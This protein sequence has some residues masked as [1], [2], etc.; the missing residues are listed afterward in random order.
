MINNKVNLDVIDLIV[1]FLRYT[2]VVRCKRR[3]I[4]QNS[5]ANECYT[6]FPD[7]L[8]NCLTVI[9]IVIRK[10]FPFRVYITSVHC[11]GGK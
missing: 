10:D 4:S 11:E 3:G 1:P 9:N 2:G 8:T 6:C 7:R 5:L